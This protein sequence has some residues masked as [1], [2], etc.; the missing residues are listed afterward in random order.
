MNFR[1]HHNKKR[2]NLSVCTERL[3]LRDWYSR[4]LGQWLLESEIEVLETVLPNLF[5]YHL[6]QVGC[7][8]D[9]G[10]LQASR[11]S[12]RMVIDMIDN[13]AVVSAINTVGQPEALPVESDCI[14]V[15]VLPHT[16]EFEENPH[17]VLREVDRI[18]VPEGHVVILGFNPWSFWGMRRIIPFRRSKP[19]WCGTF[20]GVIRIKDW[21][22]LLGFDTVF[23]QN[24]FFRPPINHEGI[25][26]RLGFVEKAGERFWPFF[27]GSY[28]LVAK[29]RVATLTP[30]K[31]RW[32]SRQQLVGAGLVKP[33]T[34][35]DN[36]NG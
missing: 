28:C 22:A 10:L 32:R 9:S 19:P 16:L 2:D 3:A 20:R 35:R 21:L 13:D 18:L 36:M 24:Y 31:P 27:S 14:D 23:I 5:G 8:A 12:H 6:V 30:I 17:E 25:M 11:I 34:N 33:T 15:V 4:G 1:R 26:R 7:L 29:K